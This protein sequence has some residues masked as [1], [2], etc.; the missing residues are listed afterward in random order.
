MKKN[1][2]TRNVRK[3]VKD[4][5]VNLER[6]W[7]EAGMVHILDKKGKQISLT[8]REAAF[9]AGQLNQMDVPAF[10]KRHNLDLIDKIIEVCREAK[11]QLE[12]S[13]PD[14]KTKAVQQL[15]SPA[16]AQLTPEQ[17]N[18]DIM[19]SA[20]P[21]LDRDE[22]RAVLREESLTG[23]IIQ[24]KKILETMNTVRKQKAISERQAAGE[25]VEVAI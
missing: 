14:S 6:I 19:A 23:D 9:R 3:A 11:H 13:S 4:N 12:D 1:A 7:A 25:S 8:V 16:A 17:V 20:Y 15:L 5:F 10:L 22:I 18:E 2:S 24:Q 21:F